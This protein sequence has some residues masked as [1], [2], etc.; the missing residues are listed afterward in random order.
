MP[1]EDG[2]CNVDR[3]IDIALAQLG[4]PYKWGAEGPGS[5]DCSGLL[6]YSFK[7][8]GCKVGSRWVT[9]TML[10]GM[11]SIKVSDA[12]PGDFL[13][14]HTGH[15]AM[16]ISSS[17]IVEAPRTGIPVR[18][19]PL[20]SRKWAFA[21]RYTTPGNGRDVGADSGQSGSIFDGVPIAQDLATIAGFITNLQTWAR[22]GCVVG[23]VVL[24]N[25][26]LIKIAAG[27]GVEKIVGKPQDAVKAVKG[28][29]PN[30]G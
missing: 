24:L 16:K 14:P 10:S 11:R 19:Q 2:G 29:I 4:K 23:G 7:K 3:A 9:K 22:I 15:V 28:A 6:W 1:I 25:L 8:A 30:G 21:R 5:F 26:A 20:N 12:G 13:F 17:K 27:T 18:V